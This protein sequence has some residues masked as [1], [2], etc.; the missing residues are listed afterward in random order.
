[1][2]D[3]QKSCKACFWCF[4]GVCASHS[5]TEPDTYGTSCDELSRRF[6]LGCE[7]FRQNLAF[8]SD[9]DSNGLHPDLS[10]EQEKFCDGFTD[11]MKNWRA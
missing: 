4:D 2:D 7:E 9:P 5:I 3:M 6:P 11:A 8:L 10:D 1:M